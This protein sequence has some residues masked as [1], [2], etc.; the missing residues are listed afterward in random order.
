MKKFIR[1]VI[2]LVIIVIIAA[3]SIFTYQ[4]HTYSPGDEAIA[5]DETALAYYIDNYEEAR[6]AFRDEAALLRANYA[7][8][9]ALTITVPSRVDSDLT[10]DILYL[11]AQQ[12]KSKLLIL[13]AGVHGV[14]GFTGSAVARMFMQEFITP[15]EL[16]DT[17]LLILHAVNP[18]GFKNSRRVSENN[19]DMNRNAAFGDEL[20]QTENPG[21]RD[22]YDLI[23]PV[24]PA[25]SSSMG[26]RFFHLRAVTAIIQKSMQSLRQAI[27][28]GQYEFEEGV[29]FGGFRLEPQYAELVPVITPVIN[30]YPTVLMIDLHT[31]YGERGTLH[32]L[33]MPQEDPQ[34]RL[35]LEEVFRGFAVD[36]GDAEDF[37]TV[38]GDF[39]S[40]VGAM[41]E[42][43]LYLP[44]AFEYGTMDSQTMMGSIK[45]LHTTLL[46]NQGYIYGYASPEDEQKITAAFVEMY[47]PS[48]PEWR[49]MVIRDSRA[50]FSATLE[51]LRKLP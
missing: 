47:Y 8:A 31:G 29:F 36:W 12:E 6:T 28:Q 20:Y 49:V 10:V 25:D 21:Y 18:Y 17:G 39:N 43:G 22:V 9:E 11:P 16:S 15:D 51:N 1:F 7:E 13:S 48:S 45:S 5:I 50:V 30:E 46:E 44:M 4:F 14:E 3:V 33:T 24:G 32:L 19:V 40:F 26:N 35:M 37:Y 41:K 42:D 34:V 27:L 38:T 2:T 23:N